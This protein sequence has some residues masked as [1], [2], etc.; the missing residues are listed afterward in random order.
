MSAVIADTF[1]NADPDRCSRLGRAAA[2]FRE[3]RDP[4]SMHVHAGATRALAGLLQVAEDGGAGAA[5]LT[6]APGLGKTLLRA[7]LQQRHDANRC[8]VVAVESGLFDFDDLLLETLSQ[9]RGERLLPQHLPGRYERIAELKSVLATNIAASG[10]HVALLLDDA[11]QYQPATLQAIGTLLNLSSEQHTFV[12]PIF[13]GAPSLRHALARLPLLR[14]RIGAHYALA[15]FEPGDSASYLQHR[16]QL[17]DLECTDVF[18]PGIVGKLHVAAGGVPRVLN[19][20]CRLAFQYASAH[21]RHAVGPDCVQAA[22]AQLPDLGALLSPVA[23][24]Q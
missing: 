10:R 17:A 7:A 4:R 20:L 9:L 5:V 16:L 8:A 15:S 12:V 24:G 23:I 6:G 14:Q 11:D 1:S 21:G 2:A 22:I 13:F 3:T 18:T 19:S